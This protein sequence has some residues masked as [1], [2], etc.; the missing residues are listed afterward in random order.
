MGLLL[1]HFAEAETEAQAGKAL[2][3]HWGYKDGH[4]VA[5]APGGLAV[6]P[7]SLAQEQLAEPHGQKWHE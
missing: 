1:T 3:R 4:G 7:R 5:P 2:A 6:W